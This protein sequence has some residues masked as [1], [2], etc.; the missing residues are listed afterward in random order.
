M[1]NKKTVIISFIL[2]VV[3]VFLNHFLAIFAFT[4]SLSIIILISLLI[5][6]K[7]I[8]LSSIFKSLLLASLIQINDIGVKLYAGGSHDGLAYGWFN[9]MLLIEFLIA[10]IILIF[11]ILIL[12]KSKDIN[13]NEW[14]AV[15]L[16]PIMFFLHLLVFSQ[17]GLG[18]NYP[19]VW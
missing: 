9:L 2:I 18:R 4:F 16:F 3:S 15:L 12:K 19:L 13:S 8:E 5:V 17:L 1:K 14:I 7:N 6:V 10:Y 11:G